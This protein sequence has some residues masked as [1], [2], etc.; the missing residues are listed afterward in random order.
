MGLRLPLVLDTTVL[1]NFSHARR[2]DVVH[3]VSRGHALTTP[4][5]MAELRAGVEHHGVPECDWSWVTVV[6]LTPEEEQRAD[7]WALALDP[8]E[9]EALAVVLSRGGTLC[10]DDLAARRMATHMGVPVCGTIGLLVQAV[11]ERM[12]DIATADEM[13]RLMRARGYRSP[14]DSLQ[15]ALR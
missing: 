8:G 12:I 4:S 5:V 9:R 15:E 7:E 2:P 14:V 10:S 1:S 6:P 13:L 11:K 3:H